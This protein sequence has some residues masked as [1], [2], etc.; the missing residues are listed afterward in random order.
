MAGLSVVN[1]LDRGKML[2]TEARDA[3]A[4]L[5]DS[6]NSLAGKLVVNMCLMSMLSL[7]T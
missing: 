3:R 7:I 2:S 1:G 5:A 4:Q 6:T